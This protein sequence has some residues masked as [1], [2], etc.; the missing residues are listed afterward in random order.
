MSKSDAMQASSNVNYQDD[1]NTNLD[2]EH[3]LDVTAVEVSFTMTFLDFSY[4]I[5]I[6]FEKLS[7]HFAQL[8]SIERVG[9][10]KSKLQIS[11]MVPHNPA[12]YSSSTS[13][14]TGHQLIKCFIHRLLQFL[15]LTFN[16]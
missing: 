5:L 11:R 9:P 3:D 15:F 4:G 1:I 13:R 16:P 14:P 12:L 6:S 2:Q 7:P 8:L 10:D